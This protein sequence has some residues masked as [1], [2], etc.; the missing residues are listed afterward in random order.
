[1]AQSDLRE[2]RS[3]PASALGTRTRILSSSLRQCGSTC[4]LAAGRRPSMSTLQRRAISPTALPG[5]SSSTMPGAGGSTGLWSGSSI[6]PFVRRCM[7]SRPCVTST[8]SG[9]AS[10]RSRSLSSTRRARPD[11]SFSPSWQPSP[12]WSVSS[13]PTVYARGCDKLLGG[14]SASAGRR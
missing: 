12:R 13:S 11:V 1:M 6:A 14:V 3:M 2:S 7:P 9:W 4:P 5:R 10:P 8:T